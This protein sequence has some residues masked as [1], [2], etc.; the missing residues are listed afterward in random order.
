MRNLSLSAVLPAAL[1]ALLFAGC[2]GNDAGNGDTHLYRASLTVTKAG[3]IITDMDD[4]D[5]TPETTRSLFVGGQSGNRFALLW[6]DYDQ[7]LVYKDGTQIGSLTPNTTGLEQST[8]TG[9]VEGSLSI[10]DELTLYMPS[11]NLVFTGQKGTIA[12]LSR[13]YSF[14]TSTA[15]VASIDGTTVTTEP[16]TLSTRQA[17]ALLKFRK[18]NNELI[19]VMQLTVKAASGK[20]VASKSLD[21]TTV[22]TDELVITTEK[23]STNVNDYPTDIYIALL[24]EYDDADS[25]TFTVQSTD[26]NTYKS[27]TAL[28]FQF[29]NGM[30]TTARRAMLCSTIDVGVTTGITPTDDIIVSAG[31]GGSN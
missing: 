3:G 29:E 31:E 20:L 1:L 21:G 5:G 2:S 9:V 22:Y 23:E 7:A 18:E 16:V 15:R 8:L 26:G 28:N 11:A 14:M 25:Y 27:K 4:A 24:N 19:H 12:N 30:L 6:D 13:N 10:G 17:Y